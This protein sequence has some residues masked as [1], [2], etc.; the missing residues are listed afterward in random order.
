[1]LME[2]SPIFSILSHP[3]PLTPQLRAIFTV[4]KFWIPESK[5]KRMEAKELH[6][7]H[8]IC[9]HHIMYKY[10]YQNVCKCTPRL[11]DLLARAQNALV[12]P[13][14]IHE[15]LSLITRPLVFSITLQ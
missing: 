11:A 5:N 1:M 8:I 12:E 6:F 14:R 15:G 9:V 2:N 13:L 3:I 7:Y 10:K 4:S